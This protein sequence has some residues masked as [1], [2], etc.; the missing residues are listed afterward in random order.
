MLHDQHTG[1]ARSLLAKPKKLK[2]TPNP[3]RQGQQRGMGIEPLTGNGAAKNPQQR[4]LGTL[5]REK[6]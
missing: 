2:G 6:F 4:L 3:F 1:V 5:G